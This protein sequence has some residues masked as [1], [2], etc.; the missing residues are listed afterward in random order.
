[1]ANDNGIENYYDS[2][3]DRAPRLGRLFHWFNNWTLINLIYLQTQ[4]TVFDCVSVYSFAQKSINW[5]KLNFYWIEI[6]NNRNKITICDDSSECSSNWKISIKRKKD[7]QR[8]VIPI[9]TNSHRSHDVRLTR[10]E[11][12][13]S[14]S[15]CVL[16]A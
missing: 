1:M 11:Q 6:K 2:Q 15:E 3:K 12:L 7:R 13:W 16:G 10:R 4:S 8:H 5:Y 9:A 14:F